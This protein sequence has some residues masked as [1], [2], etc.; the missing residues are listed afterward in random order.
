MPDLPEESD[1]EFDAARYREA[2]RSRRENAVRYL[3][4]NDDVGAVLRLAQEAKYS[5]FVGSA[6]A[7][8]GADVVGRTLLDQIDSEDTQLIAAATGW[9]TKKGA[10]N[11][12]W[13]EEALRNFQARPLGTARI[14]QVSDDLEAAWALAERDP[15]VD[16]AYWEEFSPYGR[17]PGFYL[18]EKACRRLLAHNRPLATL[19]LMSQYAK[20]SG[21]DRE[22]VVEA[23]ERLFGVPEDHP[24]RFRVD[25][26]DISELLDYA[27][28]G[29]VDKERLGTLEWRLRPVLG[30]GTH[31]PILER[32]LAREPSFFVE[33]LSMAFKPR[34]SEPEREVPP[35]VASNAFR[36]L[37]EWEVVPGSDGPKMPIDGT[38]LNAWTDDALRLLQEGDRLE[39]GLDQI[40]KL[41][42]KAG[43]D[44][45]DS[46]PARPVRDLVERT[47]RSELDNGFRAQIYNSRGVTSRG[48]AEG[49][50]QERQLS[51]H[52]AEL[53]SAIR[54]GWPRPASVLQ[55]IADGYATEAHHYDQQAERFLEGMDR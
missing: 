55:S 10:D 42:A 3:V 33:V 28:D 16:A 54:A 24:E 12:D 52:F 9:A 7:D 43:G 1:Q 36:L 11:W 15:S 27:R 4:E 34:S 23:L 13:I 45:D 49:G 29:E 48:L 8:A 35:P 31:S 32:K 14:L 20:A 51:D 44:D 2:V 17:G 22:L 53:A 25:G 39:I 21:M 40:G 5:W 37:D 38:R 6:V 50:D 19:M 46:W 18:A 47:A 41:L 30:F 26:H